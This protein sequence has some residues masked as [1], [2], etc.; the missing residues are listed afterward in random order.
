MSAAQNRAREALKGLVAEACEQVVVSAEALGDYSGG[1]AFFNP[2][3]DRPLCG[4][5]GFR[6]ACETLEQIPEFVGAIGAE[7]VERATLQFLYQYFRHSEN[8]GVDEDAFVATFET[9]L[10]ELEDPN[11]TYVAFANLRSF[12]SDDAVIDFG[13]GISI[14]HRSLE[15]I[16]QRLGWTEWHLE[17]LRRDW[18]EGLPASG[19]VVWVETVKE[20]G[21]ET[22]ILSDSATGPGR[23]LD[24]LLALWLFAPGDVSVGAIFTNRA[25]GFDLTGRGLARSNGMPGDLWGRGYELAATDAPDVRAIYEDVLAF[26][27]ATDVPSNV[28]LAV[29]RFESV[30]T[31]SVR[32]RED[33]II[34]QL[35]ALEAL[36]GSGTELRFRLAFRISS[37]LASDD[38]ERLAVFEAVKRYYDIRSKI[39]HGTDLRPAERALVDDDTELRSIVRRVLRAVIFATVHT[40]LRLTSSYIDQHLDAALLSTASRQALRERFALVQ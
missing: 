26:R 5:P 8:P 9:L 18:M 20:K 2:E 38:E 23:I 25:A 39:V 21:P 27:N 40:D 31:R 4:L 10:N 22:A 36:V 28:R 1:T 6:P 7:H 11:W 15:D 32:Q 35:I 19:H 16:E 30:Y 24:L 17:H 14:R 37:L 34:D 33:R 3:R 29:R 12:H 13:N